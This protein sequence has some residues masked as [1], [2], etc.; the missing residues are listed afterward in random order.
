VA[1]E[2][3]AARI[4]DEGALV[5]NDRVVELRLLEVRAHGAEHPA[6]DDDE[7]NSERANGS[8]GLDRALREERVLADQ[9]AVEIA[10][11]RLDR[12][13]KVSG[14]SQPEVFSTT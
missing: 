7:G 13:R 1:Q 11:D 12:A 6:G 3:T 8:N 10:R 5:A 9:G 4:G 2:R 14:K